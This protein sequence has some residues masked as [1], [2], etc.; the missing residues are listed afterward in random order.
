MAVQRPARPRASAS[1]GRLLASGAVIVTVLYLVLYG[2]YG[3]W[4]PSAFSAYTFGNLVNNA[5]PLAIA[6]AGE[7]LVVLARGFDLSV[8]GVMS[9]TNVVMATYPVDGTG[10]RARQPAPLHGGRRVRRG[11]QRLRGRLPAPA[12]DRRDARHD[13][14]LPGSSAWSS[15]MRLAAR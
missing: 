3:L 9:L 7:T 4:E 11:S 2:L 13:D 12:V 14:H 6:A 15:S 1:R 10:R 5:S 8:A